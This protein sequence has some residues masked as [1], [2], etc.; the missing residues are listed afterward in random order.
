MFRALAIV[1]GL[2]GCSVSSDVSREIGARCDSALECDDRCLAPGTAFP[3]GFCSV[4]CE[5]D[6]ACPGGANC[7]AAE[8]GVCLFDCVDDANCGFLGEGW[9]CRELA[10]REDAAQRVKVCAG[11]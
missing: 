2:A 1:A 9:R 7:V 5:R 10:L 6:S 4:S 3:G 11:S 8:G